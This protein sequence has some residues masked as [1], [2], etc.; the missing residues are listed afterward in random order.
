MLLVVKV[1]PLTSA[2]NRP[3]IGTGLSKMGG[4]KQEE[5][6]DAVCAGGNWREIKLKHRNRPT[7]PEAKTES[8]ILDSLPPKTLRKMPRGKDANKQENIVNRNY[9]GGPTTK[10]QEGR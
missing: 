8:Q 7:N 3:E 4:A 5:A 1:P 10:L 2:K 6:S 9:F